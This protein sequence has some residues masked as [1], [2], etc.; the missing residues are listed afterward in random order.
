MRGERGSIEYPQPDAQ[1]IDTITRE[2][3]KHTS[4]ERPYRREQQPLHAFEQPSF[5]FVMIS[6]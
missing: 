2:L 6:A 3:M 4:R 1:G 5:V